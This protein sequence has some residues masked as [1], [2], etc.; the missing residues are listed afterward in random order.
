MEHKVNVYDNDGNIIGKSTEN[1]NVIKVVRHEH[2]IN[3]ETLYSY[4]NH[5]NNGLVCYGM[6]LD[7]GFSVAKLK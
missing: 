4:N 3:G 2:H 7:N 6:I 5:L 1:V